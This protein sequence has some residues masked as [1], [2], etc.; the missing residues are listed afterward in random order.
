MK[1]KKKTHNLINV[2]SAKTDSLIEEI[3]SKSSF[4]LL[5]NNSA[6]LRKAPNSD[7]DTLITVFEGQYLDLI[8]E[9]K[10]WYKVQFFNYE[11]DSL[12]TGWI[13]KGHV[14]EIREKE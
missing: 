13:Y 5:A 9:I 10:R 14:D 2:L 7:S 3:Q 12:G 4:L 1:I 8:D 6:P 11:V